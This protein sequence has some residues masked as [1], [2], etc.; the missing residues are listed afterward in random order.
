MYKIPY[1]HGILMYKIPY[2]HGILMYTRYL[3]N[4]V[5]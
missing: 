2:K 3:T 5:F 1:K 4:M